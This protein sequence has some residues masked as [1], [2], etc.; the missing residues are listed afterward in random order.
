MS[1]SVATWNVN[2]LRARMDL[3]T[4]WLQSNNID[5]ICLQETKVEDEKFPQETFKKMGYHVVFKGEKT[6]NGVCTLSSYP[7]VAVKKDFESIEGKQKRILEVTIEGGITIINAYFPHGKMVGSDS[8]QLKIEFIKKLRD[9]I[10]KNFDESDKTL[11]VGDFNVAPEEIDVYD[12][13]ILQYYIGFSIDERNAVKELYSIGFIDIF[14]L[15]NKESEEYSWWDYRSNSFK[16]NAGMRVDH[17][18]GFEEI[19]K[20]SKKCFIDRE[21]RAKPKPSDHAPVISEFY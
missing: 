19:S 2:S 17:I 8:F 21:M 3:L 5:I 15:H 9:Y 4:G 6:Y 1:I 18:W 16:R 14:R 7:F 10:K 20:N 11:L 12:P 13:E